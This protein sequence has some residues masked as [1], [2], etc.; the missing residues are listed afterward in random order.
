VG[1][2][3]PPRPKAIGQSG[4]VKLWN[5]TLPRAS[6]IRTRLIFNAIRFLPS[7]LATF[8]ASCRHPTRLARGAFWYRVGPC[9]RPCRPV[10]DIDQL[11]R[12]ALECSAPDQGMIRGATK[13]FLE[14]WVPTFPHG[15]ANVPANENSNWT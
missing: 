3:Q 12:R 14:V 9:P 1:P 13:S 11:V 6:R 2:R 15:V 5:V 4:R 10:A 8:M 7:A